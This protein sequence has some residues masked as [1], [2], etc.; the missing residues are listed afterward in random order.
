MI[1]SF[2]YRLYLVTDEAACLGRDFFWVVEEAIKGGVDV[3]QLREKNL[4]EEAFYL[5]AKSLKV[6]CQKYNVPL[7]IN[8]S[9]DVAKAVGADGIHV[10]QSDMSISTVINRVG[11]MI[12]VGLS[13]DYLEELY[14]EDANDAWYYGVSPIFST[15]TKSDTRAVW[16]LEGLQALRKLTEKKLV[17][18]G[19]V[20]VENAA[21]IIAAGADCLAVVSAICS[22]DDPAHAAKALKKEI[23]RGLKKS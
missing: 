10:G 19:N 4:N 3:I 5:K 20:K 12:P 7:I 2:P 15:P 8:D 11:D 14:A 6:I 22:A 23:D 18:I 16:G 17:A 13:L 1:R 21:E 9:V